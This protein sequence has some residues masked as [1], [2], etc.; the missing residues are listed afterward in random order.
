METCKA[1]SIIAKAHGRNDI[2][3]IWETCEHLA[4][5]VSSSNGDRN[6][7]YGHPDYCSATNH[8]MKVC[9]RKRYHRQFGRNA[10]N[11][12]IL[13]LIEGGRNDFQT[14][15]MIVCTFTPNMK[16][17]KSKRCAF[18]GCKIKTDICLLNV[19]VYFLNLCHICIFS[20][21]CPV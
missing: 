5:L 9:L 6:V 13:S 21:T 14:A 18:A 15:A 8:A 20:L 1:N 17:I 11:P 16:I 19:A 3:K 10:L 12:I 4:D 2:A 7:L